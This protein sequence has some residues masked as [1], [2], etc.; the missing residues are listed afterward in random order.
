MSLW[1]CQHKW[2]LNHEL[3]VAILSHICVELESSNC[4]H[5]KC[6]RLVPPSLSEG[7][8]SEQSDSKAGSVFYWKLPGSAYS[9]SC[10]TKA[11]KKKGPSNH[12]I[13]TND[14]CSVPQWAS[15]WWHMQ[16]KF[17]AKWNLSRL[18]CAFTKQISY[19]SAQNH[20]SCTY[21]KSY[22]GGQ[23]GSYAQ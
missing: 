5:A 18:S 16:N 19:G 10:L 17:C 13:A 22:Q 21:K 11:P 15:I 7:L 3:R 9:L 12:S 2:L 14:C 23:S 6:N 4:F 20:L 1:Q 8:S